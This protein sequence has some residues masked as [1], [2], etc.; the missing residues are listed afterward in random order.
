MKVFLEVFFRRL[1]PNQERKLELH[2][3][4]GKPDLLGKLGTRLRSYA[5]VLQPNWRLIVLVD[6]D[7]DDCRALK[8]SLNELAQ[9]AGLQ[10]KD[11]STPVS[12]Q[13]ATR[14][15]VEELEAWYFGDWEAVRA[16]YPRVPASIPK[17][18]KFRD[19]D[20]ITGGTCEAFERE[21]QEAGYF[22]S[23]LR[24]IELASELATRMNL[25]PAKNRSRSFRN[26][27]ALFGS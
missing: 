7:G 17:N 27:I 15:V 22:R 18:K 3:F 14:I 4:R 2:V 21:M 11:A 10:V 26:L 16:A 24:K 19:P 6:R 25:D 20:A 5:K 23:G 12:W 1:F 8:Q 9:Q 13:V